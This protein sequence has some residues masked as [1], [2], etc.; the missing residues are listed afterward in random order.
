MDGYWKV[1]VLG[2]LAAMLAGCA[3]LAPLVT[4]PPASLPPGAPLEAQLRQR[5]VG[6]WDGRVDLA[7]PDATL[8]IDGVRLE[9]GAWV[10]DAVYGTTNLFLSAV[11]ATLQLT[12][13]DIVVAFRTDLGG[14]RLRLES[15]DDLR[16][17]L[18]LAT[19]D[20]PR[21][22]TLRR[23]AAT[24]GIPQARPS[25]AVERVGRRLEAQEHAAPAAAETPSAADATPPVVPSK[26]AS[27]PTA[28]PPLLVGRWE[29]SLDFTVS[30]RLLVVDSV[31]MEAGAWQVQAR[32][33]VA[34]AD[35][36]PV[37]V[38]PDLSDDRIDLRFVT[39]LASRVVL[40]LHADDSLR[41]QFRLPFMTRDPRNE[42]HRS[43]H[44]NT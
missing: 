28:L 38:T 21:A 14:V 1:I 41:G 15:D 30:A 25:T 6:R 40:R 16:G 23:L 43:K 39:S 12:G 5:L 44:P 3:T 10:V 24:R 9:R 20:T 2:A 37:A 33:A 34:D 31:R 19:D 35:L 18:T 42:L 32:F 8:M 22:L 27:L 4:A 11:P 36:A 17:T 7:F 29:G 13:A 26:V